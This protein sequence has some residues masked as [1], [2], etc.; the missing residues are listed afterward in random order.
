MAALLFIKAFHFE[1]ALM[2]EHFNENYMDS[3]KY[4]KATF[5]G[6]LID[7]DLNKISDKTTDVKLKGTLN[8]RGKE[9]IIDVIAQ[10]KKEDDKIIFTSNFS[11]EPQEFDIKIPTIVRDKIAK[12]INLMLKYELNKKN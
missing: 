1:I 7:F 2:Q 9:K 5:K 3:D 6:K 4:P 12:S 11:V 10:L 8:V